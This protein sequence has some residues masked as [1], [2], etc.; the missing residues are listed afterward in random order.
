MTTAP[1]YIKFRLLLP[2]CS[3]TKA[4]HGTAEQH[5]HTHTHTPTDTHTQTN[6][7]ANTTHTHTRT[8]T[9]THTHTHTPTRSFLC[10]PLGRS[11][12]TALVSSNAYGRSLLCRQPV[13]FRLPDCFSGPPQ[14]YYCV[15]V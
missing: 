3:Q 12:L 15:P 4:Q 14:A 11:T 7:T 5:V 2:H 13:A 1:C 8:H 6:H 9:H 10:S